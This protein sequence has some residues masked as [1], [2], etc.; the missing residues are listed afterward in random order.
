LKIFGRE[1]QKARIA[2]F[3]VGLVDKDDKG[4]L[5]VSLLACLIEAENTITQVLFFKFK[6]AK[7][8]FRSNTA[9]VS[10]NRRSLADL[11]PTIREKIRAYQTNYLSSIVDL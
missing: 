10:I 3:Q 6:E 7:A 9:K 8:S 4:D 11:S 5:F 1:S 2:R